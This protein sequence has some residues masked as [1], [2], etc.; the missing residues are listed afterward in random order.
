MCRSRNADLLWRYAS[1]FDDPEVLEVL[2][3]LLSEDD[4]R[5]PIA[6]AR[7]AALDAAF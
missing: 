4:H 6:R 7:R 3:T 5:L 2:E 1:R